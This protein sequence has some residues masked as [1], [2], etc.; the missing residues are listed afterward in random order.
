M[1]AAEPERASA[2]GDRRS[3]ESRALELRQGRTLTLA[4]DGA[5]ELIEIRAASGSLEL[6]IR[7]TDQ[8][9]ALEIETIRLAL[10]AAEAID[11]E[12]KELNVAAE[13]SLALSSLGEITVSG[14]AD[15]H[16]D[17]DGDVHVQ[18]EMIYL[19]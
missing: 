17:A 14:K 18:G 2:Q 15:V 4:S 3:V 7:M 11:I 13:R 8:G 16:V 9:P 12:C 19:N 6:R 5:D 1:A 10:R